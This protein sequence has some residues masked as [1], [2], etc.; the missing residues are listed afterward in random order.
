MAEGEPCSRLDRTGALPELE[1]AFK[2][3]GAHFIAYT[4]QTLTAANQV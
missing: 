4:R 3:G 1:Q 2:E